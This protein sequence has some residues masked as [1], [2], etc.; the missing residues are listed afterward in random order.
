[1]PSKGEFT[2]LLLGDLHSL[3]LTQNFEDGR[4]YTEV[5]ER[6]IYETH[7]EAKSCLKTRNRSAAFR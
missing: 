7:M 4:G 6:A 3:H 1:M 5:M 2:R